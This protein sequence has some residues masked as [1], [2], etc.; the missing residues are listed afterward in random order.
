MLES[1]NQLLRAVSVVAND[2]LWVK[3]IF[4]LTI[5]LVAFSVVLFFAFHPQNNDEGRL[6][7]ARQAWRAGMGYNACFQEFSETGTITSNL[8]GLAEQTQPYFDSLGIGVVLLDELVKKS[9]LVPW[10]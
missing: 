7:S 5:I 3:G 1:V 6:S 4:G 10:N 8:H 2:P 9:R